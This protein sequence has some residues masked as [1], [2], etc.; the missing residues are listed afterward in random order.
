MD[1]RVAHPT[2][3]LAVAAAFYELLELPVLASFTDHDGYSGVV[4]G[5]PDAS[6]QLELVAHEE[7]TPSPTAEDQLVLY[8]GSAEGVERA[9]DRLRA[10]GFEPSAAPNPYWARNGAV[11]FV[12][13]DGYWLVL[14]P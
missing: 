6:R 7:T 8:L 14:S 13:P 9:A 2:R 5:L 10:A 11:C 1:V 3:D 12:D 4:F